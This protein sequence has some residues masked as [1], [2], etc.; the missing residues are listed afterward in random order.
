M[1]RQEAAVTLC[2]V[3]VGGSG[4]RP[5]S[6]ASSPEHRA[7]VSPGP[8][9]GGSPVDRPR[10]S[11][12]CCYPAPVATARG[13][14]VGGRAGGLSPSRAS[15]EE[16][17]AF[18]GIPDPVSQ[19]RRVSGRLQEQPDVDDMQLRAAL[20]AAKLRDIESS[21]GM[22]VDQSN[23]ILH[24]TDAEIIHNANQI[25]FSLGNNEFEV[26]R[27]VNDILDLEADRA[28]DMI[29]HIAAVKPMNDS[30]IDALGVRVLDGMCA[31]LDPDGLEA[32][33]D[34]Q[35]ET[36]LHVDEPLVL[37]VE[38]EGYVQ[39]DGQVKPKRTWKRKVYPVSAVRRSARIRT[40]K[41]FHD[42]L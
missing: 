27:S 20:R 42:D 17:I 5:A 28:V 22:S 7:R 11:S 2:P 34:S 31:D 32:E 16:V 24:F 37:E 21:T 9:A 12:S 30:E 38:N 15:R 18:G 40:A 25:G 23:S 33:E 6:P 26:S 36:S 13:A 4:H 8:V 29:R 39:V 3:A 14:A 41:K 19:G 1:A 10:E 35:P